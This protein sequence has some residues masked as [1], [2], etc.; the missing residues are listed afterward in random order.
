MENCNG[1]LMGLEK[2]RWETRFQQTCFRWMSKGT[3]FTLHY[4]SHFTFA[5][6][7]W[8]WSELLN[9]KSL[10]I[11]VKFSQSFTFCFLLFFVILISSYISVSFSLCFLPE[12]S[13][14]IVQQNMEPV[15]L[16]I[17]SFHKLFAPLAPLITQILLWAGRLE[18][19]AQTSSSLSPEFIVNDQVLTSVRFTL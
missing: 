10:L 17:H 13:Y 14:D 5:L 8:V 16:G 19:K 18:A 12:L 15:N 9:L 1:V 11:P 7:K 6:R 4:N 2:E 3:R